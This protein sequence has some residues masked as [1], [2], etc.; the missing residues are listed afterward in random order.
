MRNAANGVTIRAFGADAKLDAF[1][2][3]LREDAPSPARVID[4]RAA[5]IPDEGAS[6]FIIESSDAAWM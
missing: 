2:K 6:G 5:V 3:Q 1:V 4:L